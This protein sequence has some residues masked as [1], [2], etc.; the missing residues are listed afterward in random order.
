MSRGRPKSVA[1][2]LREQQAPRNGQLRRHAPAEDYGDEQISPELRDTPAVFVP[3][4]A[5]DGAPAHE[6]RPRAGPQFSLLNSADFAK[7][8]YRLEWLVRRLLVKGQPG[9]VG[10]PRKSLKT[11]VAVDLAL[12]LGTGT[13]FLGCFEVPAKTRVV[14]LS[15]ESGEAVLQETA[16]RVSTSKGIDLA[17]ADVLWGFRLPQLANVEHLDLL[18]EALQ[19]AGAGVVVIDPLYLCLIAGSDL[20]ASNMMMMGPLFMAVAQACLSVGCTPLLAHHFRQTRQDPYGEPQ[21]EDLAFS[22]CQE[23]AR[24]W[25]LLGRREKYQPG[26]GSHSL[27]LVAG[28]SAGQS[29]GWALD[30]EEGVTGEDFTGRRW[31]V[32]VQT[33]G[34]ARRAAEDDGDAAKFRKQ[35][36]QQQANDRELMAAIDRLTLRGEH[37]TSLGEAAAGYTA[38]RNMAG[39]SG[40]RMIQAVDRLLVAGAVRK[41]KVVVPTGVAERT[42]DGLQRAKEGV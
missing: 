38:A 41:V 10:G 17:G 20:Q 37:L 6:R 4:D 23:F 7:A 32:T 1:E 14:L 24:Q 19:Q 2:R 8:D 12:S 29:G 5:A 25:L 40:R 42:A 9:I 28:G 35:A 22:G 26:S 39:L 11:S 21:L 36:E 18:R 13:R 30:I 31:D 34:E 27:W 15:G 3:G 33:A 16:R